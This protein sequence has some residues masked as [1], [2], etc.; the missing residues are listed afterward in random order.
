MSVCYYK[1]DT[2]NISI[3]S[4]ERYRY[5]D[6]KLIKFNIN[7]NK[8][9]SIVKGI[10]TDFC[11]AKVIGYNE[12]TNKYWCKMYDKNYC[13]LYIELEILK[14]NDDL[15]FVNLLPLVGSNIL[16]EEFIIN[17]KESIQLYKTSS[18]IRSYLESSRG[19]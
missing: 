6:V 4:V 14:H 5:V 19:L 2:N 1:M 11:E 18:F 13:R 10:L 8:L 16:I 17:F 9:L 7:I 12:K 3:K 15:S